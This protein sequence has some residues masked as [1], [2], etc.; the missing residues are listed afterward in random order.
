MT[1]I[2]FWNLMGS[3]SCDNWWASAKKKKQQQQIIPGY[4]QFDPK[5]PVNI[6]SQL[7]FKIDLNTLSLGFPGSSAG[8]ESTCNAGR[9]PGEG[10]GYPLQYSW[11]SLAAKMVKNPLAMQET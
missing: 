9:S 5:F 1:V 8:K 2:N 11:T 4:L 10:I 6:V 3:C 7:I